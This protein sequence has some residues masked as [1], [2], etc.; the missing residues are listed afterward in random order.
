M[1]HKKLLSMLAILVLVIGFLCIGITQAVA[2]DSPYEMKT[3][4]ETN[5]GELNLADVIKEQ[6]EKVAKA[7]QAAELKEL[8]TNALQKI[9][10]AKKKY[11]GYM[12]SKQ[13]KSVKKSIQYIKNSKT[14]TKVRTHYKKTDKVF[15]SAKKCKKYVVKW[16][17]RIDKYLK[18]SNM[19]GCGKYYALAAWK[20][21]IDPRWAPA[22]S[23]VESGKGAAYVSGTYN[24]WG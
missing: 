11:I 10:K 9:R 8:K 16:T 5:N 7:K 20:N 22:I 13:K 15:D 23:C 1:I 24:A 2:E 18:N 14:K 4:Y 12:T 6:E 21:S 19:A 17:K 3:E